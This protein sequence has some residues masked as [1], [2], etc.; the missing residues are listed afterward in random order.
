MCS[1][2]L[3]CRQQTVPDQGAAA[4]FCNFLSILSRTTPTTHLAGIL[5]CVK[6]LVALSSAECLVSIQ[7][8]IATAACTCTQKRTHMF[9]IASVSSFF[10]GMAAEHSHGFQNSHV[11]I[12]GCRCDAASLQGA[13][14]IG[15]L[16]GALAAG[17]PHPPHDNF[18]CR[19]G[20]II[21]IVFSP[22][23][24]PKTINYSCE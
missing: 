11:R 13:R 9:G 17:A 8:S 12:Q 22:L 4:F 16:P 3:L 10:F 23:S 20:L 5:Q 24:G 6:Q 14:N 2:Q 18:Y 7:G 1:V 19:H 15:I 21:M